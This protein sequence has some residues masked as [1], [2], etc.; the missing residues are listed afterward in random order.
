MKK[1]MYVKGLTM[2]QYRAK[3]RIEELERTM[4]RCDDL[5]E[6]FDLFCEADD[7]WN[8]NFQMESMMN[9][10]P[11]FQ[12]LHEKIFLMRQEILEARSKFVTS[13]LVNVN[14]GTNV[15][16]NITINGKEA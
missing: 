4:K 9:P 5:D 8:Y 2:K 6:L 15:T 7:I 13:A 1:L 11:N 10:D 16:V 14:G 12:P 3:E